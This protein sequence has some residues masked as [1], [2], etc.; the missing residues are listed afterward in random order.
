[1]I[2]RPRTNFVLAL[3]C[4]ALACFALS[5]GSAP[6]RAQL[7]PAAASKPAVVP[8]ETP[9]WDALSVEE[10]RDLLSRFSDEQVRQIIIGQLDRAVDADGAQ[11]GDASMISG[12]Q[13]RTH[14][15]RERL[16]RLLGEVRNIPSAFTFVHAKLTEGKSPW[17]LLL[18]MGGMTLMFTVG[19][20]IEWL[21]RRWTRPA[22][23]R[24]EQAPAR[25]ISGKVGYFG[26][27]LLLELA[28]LVVFTIGVMATFFVLYQGFEPI[29]NF[30]MTYVSVV[31]VIRVVSLTS[32]V[33]V[34]LEMP[35]LRMIPFDD[36]EAH[37]YHR[38]TVWFAGVT[39]FGF[40]TCTL[41]LIL[42]LSEDLHLVLRI[43]VGLIITAMLCMMIWHGRHGIA[44]LIRADEDAGPAERQIREILAEMWHFAAIAYV[45]AVVALTLIRRLSG[46]D[47]NAGISFGSMF[48]VVAVPLLD[49]AIGR[50]LK[51]FGARSR[52]AHP[53]SIGR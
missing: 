31:L 42:G 23:L 2:I 43:M 3:I 26:L 22:R 19:G 18:V 16:G 14:L 50:I 21:F 38:C 48:I 40:M 41:M 24:F 27:R 11:P 47:I 45:L 33:I 13:A 49:A 37:Y 5:L 4:A 39:T 53:M 20:L 44:K 7:S 12:F 1:M 8:I 30:V 32:R 28:A 6:V 36:A 29:R 34:A 25:Q 46:E 51:D 9:N 10:R 35:H 15:V 52:H 17:L